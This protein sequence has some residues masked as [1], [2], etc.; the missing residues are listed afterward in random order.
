MNPDSHGHEV[1]IVP[2]LSA[3]MCPSVV[4]GIERTLECEECGLRLLGLLLTSPSWV[5]RRVESVSFRDHRT[6]RRQVSVDFS[7]PRSAPAFR[8][9]GRP[10]ALLPLTVMRRKS[11]VNFDLRDESDRSI[12]LVNVRQNQAVMLALVRVWAAMCLDVQVLPAEVE[13]FVKK[14]VAGTQ[15]ELYDAYEDAH[16]AS[17]TPV[18]RRLVSDERF[19]V[20]MDRV[21]E[22]FVLF[23]FVP[24]DPDQDAARRVV[25][26]R[27]DE[28]LTP[29]YRQ[30]GY[31]PDDGTYELVGRPLP[32]WS[33][34]R[35]LIALGWRPTRIRFPTPAAENC[36]SYHF[37]IHAPPGVEITTASV[38]AGRPKDP[39]PK[40]PSFDVV[41]GGLPT[42]DLHAVDVPRGS[43]SR[44]QV[45]LHVTPHPWLTLAV[46]SAW[47]TTATLFWAAATLA[48]PGRD[49]ATAS[50]LF[51][52]FTAAVA[53]VLW[54]P[55][56]HRMA[57]RL[58][59]HVG[60]LASAS[61]VLLLVAA[62]MLAFQRGSNLGGPLTALGVVATVIACLVSVTWIMAFRALSR[63]R[64]SPWEQGIQIP[65]DKRDLEK[66][67]TFET[68]RRAYGYST[69][70]IKVA[71]AES[72]YARRPTSK[73]DTP[74]STVMTEA[75]LVEVHKLL[76]EGLTRLSPSHRRPS[77][78]VGGPLASVD[79]EPQRT[80]EGRD[81]E[82]PRAHPE[83]DADRAMTRTN[84]RM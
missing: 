23:V 82:R 15:E 17:A 29:R 47:A 16:R 36:R 44:A 61:S 31:H 12:P 57:L 11:L 41:G 67:K 35:W 24:D 40:P 28:K 13:R 39:D 3:A 74:L 45:D 42:V 43:L 62:A 2:T 14:L 6:V 60:A 18:L 54:R 10:H 32:M 76:A 34:S 63:T 79:Y 70:A 52:T 50:T 19:R 80:V 77:A 30:T 26:F 9:G 73:V 78:S 21:T 75:L 72:G 8:I 68:A 56:E 46:F 48:E 38:L 22:D 37:K 7:I 65:V 71:S 33:L 1:E 81:H 58:L 25:K 5:Y 27:Y 83:S 66:R 64:S 53:A 49:N 69:P 51:V 4:D 84:S 59:S 20:V 55:S